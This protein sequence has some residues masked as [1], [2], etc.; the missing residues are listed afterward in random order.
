MSP[1]Q[2]QHEQA[3]TLKVYQ[4]AHE[5]AS[6]TGNDEFSEDALLNYDDGLPDE[7]IDEWSPNWV[8]PDSDWQI[9]GPAGTERPTFLGVPKSVCCFVTPA[10]LVYDLALASMGQAQ[11]AVAP[12]A[13]VVSYDLTANSLCPI[14]AI[15]DGDGFQL[16]EFIFDDVFRSNPGTMVE[17]QDQKRQEFN[18]L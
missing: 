17:M 15:G 2:I 16:P 7:P 13:S 14:P 8:P 5:E 9:V 18:E 4:L 1:E 11:S 6:A 10:G 12:N 3:A